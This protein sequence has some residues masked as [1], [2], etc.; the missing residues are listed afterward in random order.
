LILE[1]E[2]EFNLVIPDEQADKIRTVGE[3]MAFIESNV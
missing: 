2:K 1:F 3:A